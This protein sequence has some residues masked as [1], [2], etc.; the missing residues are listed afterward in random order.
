[1]VPENPKQK[2]REQQRLR[3]EEDRTIRHG[4]G[5][6]VVVDNK[7]SGGAEGGVPAPGIGCGWDRV[8]TVK[9]VQAFGPN[10]SGA[11]VCDV[12]EGGP[13]DIGAFI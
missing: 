5:R 1:M 13:E 9:F 3:D 6:R 11:D 2:F 12:W 10:T 8:V 7:N 4:G